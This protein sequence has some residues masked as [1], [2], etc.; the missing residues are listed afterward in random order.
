MLGL[1]GHNP[2]AR[3]RIPILTV[4]IT[5]S[6]V[7]VITGGSR[8]QPSSSLL[9]VEKLLRLR[10]EALNSASKNACQASLTPEVNPLRPC[11]GGKRTTTPQAHPLLSTQATE[12]KK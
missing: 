5:I 3:S 11:K 8:P 10:L 12:H 7:S 6:R 1:S 9:P 2:T 4:H